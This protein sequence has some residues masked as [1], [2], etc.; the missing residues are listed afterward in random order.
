MRSLTAFNEK[1]FHLI[2]ILIITG[3]ILGNLNQRFIFIRKMIT[4]TEIFAYF[5]LN[6]M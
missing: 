4:Q 6:F 1:T 2:R 3:F 5:F